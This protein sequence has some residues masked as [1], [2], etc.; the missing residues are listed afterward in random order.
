MSRGEDLRE[1]RS[2]RK[3]C[4]MPR[5]WQELG[6]SEVQPLAR[7][8]SSGDKGGRGRCSRRALGEAA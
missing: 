2:Q 7:M 4:Q 5:V 3:E 8:W 6:V 1:E